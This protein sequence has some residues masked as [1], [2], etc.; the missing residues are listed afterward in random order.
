MSK[1]PINLILA[2]AC[3]QATHGES[4]SSEVTHWPVTSRVC[5]WQVV[6]ESGHCCPNISTEQVSWKLRDQLM[7]TE[8]TKANPAAILDVPSFFKLC[9]EMMSWGSEFCTALYYVLL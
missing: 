2:N 7:T 6:V 3:F 5:L 1:G 4:F 8:M 9:T